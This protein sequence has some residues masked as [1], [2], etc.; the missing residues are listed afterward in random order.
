MSGRAVRDGIIT[1]CTLHVT[2]IRR[3][4]RVCVP[5]RLGANELITECMDAIPGRHNGLLAKRRRR[6][7]VIEWLGINL[8]ASE[9]LGEVFGP[10]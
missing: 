10:I 1:P 3:T 6:N 7:P 9:Q 8:L 4:G 2:E 5:W